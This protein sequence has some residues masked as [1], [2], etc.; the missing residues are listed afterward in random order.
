MT[1]CYFRSCGRSNCLSFL[2]P[3][4]LILLASRHCEL[5]RPEPASS[6]AKMDPQQT[7]LQR[8]HNVEK[9]GFDPF[10]LP[11]PSSHR[12]RSFGDAALTFSFSL[13]RC[14]FLF[15]FIL[16]AGLD[17][18]RHQ[19]IVRVLELAGS[20]MDELAS[21]TG[22]R[23][24][25]LAV[26]CREFMQSIKVTFSVLSLSPPANVFVLLIPTLKA[27]KITEGCK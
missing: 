23:A 4:D 22:P 15:L 8:L 10:L 26:H 6:A 18:R 3:I 11:S 25:V 20:V 27:G 24:D 12:I 13:C 17:W 14:C 1:I 19:R 2:P 5:I 9:V 16:G 7:S 21:S